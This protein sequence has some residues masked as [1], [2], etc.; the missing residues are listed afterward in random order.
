MAARTRT[1]MPPVTVRCYALKP[2][3]AKTYGAAATCT[4]RHVQLLLPP[5]SACPVRGNAVVQGA[6][7]G[8]AAEA[9]GPGSG[10]TSSLFAFRLELAR[11]PRARQSLLLTVRA[12]VAGGAEAGGGEDEE[13][14]RVRPSL[15]RATADRARETRFAA[16]TFFSRSTAVGTLPRA[17]RLVRLGC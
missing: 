8:G 11:Q 12:G 4:V 10:G 7:E 13:A 5:A 6:L 1:T 3:T 16:A 15:P 14:A 9:G 2:K 17:Q